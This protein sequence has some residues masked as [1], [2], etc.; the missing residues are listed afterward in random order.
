MTLTHYTELC[1]FVL[2]RA[3]LS[4]FMQLRLC[5][6]WQAASEWQGLNQQCS[7]FPEGASMVSV[8]T[9]SGKHFSVPLG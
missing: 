3:L 4:A 9:V 7:V 2:C 8:H 5:H 6:A 1:C